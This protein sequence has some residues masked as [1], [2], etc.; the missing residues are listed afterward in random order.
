M[1]LSFISEV[2]V[3]CTLVV[4]ICLWAPA[5]LQYLQVGRWNK[6]H[7]SRG[8]KQ[9]IQQGFPLKGPV[10]FHVTFNLYWPWEQFSPSLWSHLKCKYNCIFQVVPQNIPQLQSLSKYVVCSITGH[11]WST[12]CSSR[13][14][15]ARA[16]DILEIPAKDLQNG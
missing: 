14:F 13:L 4:S 8:R 11:A 3:Q 1:I 16:L 9:H 10:F 7:K 5:E 2:Q 12:I 6:S 15:I